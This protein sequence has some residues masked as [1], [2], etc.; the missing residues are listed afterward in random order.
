MHRQWLASGDNQGEIGGAARVRAWSRAVGIDRDL[1]SGHRVAAVGDL[2]AA[3]EARLVGAAQHRDDGGRAADDRA[4]DVAPRDFPTAHVPELVQRL[5]ISHRARDRLLRLRAAH[6]IHQPAD[7]ALVAGGARLALHRC[8][9]RGVRRT[10][11]GAGRA[12]H[13]PGAEAAVQFRRLF[14]LVRHDPPDD[15]RHGGDRPG[16]RP[17]VSRAAA[18]SRSGRNPSAVARAPA[19]VAPVREALARVPRVSAAFA[20]KGA[21]L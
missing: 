4:A 19:R 20:R 13:Q 1:R 12:A 7:R 10:R 15:H 16:A 6:R 5:R 21:E 2:P 9:G 8:G 17:A 14:Q 18:E 3:G 11:L